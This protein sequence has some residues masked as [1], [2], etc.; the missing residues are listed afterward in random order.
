M[1]YFNFPDQKG[2]ASGF[3]KRCLQYPGF[4]SQGT[5]Y[6][7]G[8]T[9]PRAMPNYKLGPANPICWP[10]G[11]EETTAKMKFKLYPN[12]VTPH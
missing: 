11:V 9:T 3:C 10:L 1:S 4:H 12:P 6:N 5:Y 2:A 8:V 7:F